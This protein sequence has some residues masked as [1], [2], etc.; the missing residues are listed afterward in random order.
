MEYLE[1]YQFTLSY[2]PDKANVVADALNCKNRGIVAS[3]SLRE[4]SMV[5]T[6]NE[7]GIAT[8][9]ILSEI[10]E[11]QRYDQEVAFIKARMESSETMLGWEIHTDGSLKYQG[12]MFVPSDNS[13]SEKVLKE[14]HHSAFAV[15]PG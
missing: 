1:D 3:L 10:L 13:L 7:F 6:L 14:F 2:H 11:S 12:Q 8:P 4:W 5:G 15:H 9:K